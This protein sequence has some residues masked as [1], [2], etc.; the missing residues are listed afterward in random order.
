MVSVTSTTTLIVMVLLVPFASRQLLKTRTAMG[1]DLIIARAGI[2]SLAFGSLLV[3]LARTSEQFIAA[4]VFYMTESCYMPA[5]I[6]I[7]AAMAGVDNLQSERTGSL[8]MAVVF[9]NN[10]GAI[11]AGPIVS[12]LLRAGMSRGG[13]WVGLPF[14]AEAAI[15]IFTICIVFSIRESRYRHLQAQQE[16]EGAAPAESDQQ[17]VRS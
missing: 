13:D 17:T 10:I 15:Q 1:K 7:I 11:V 12:S 16:E 2:L 4:L 8:Y 9:M 6:S 14:F 3:G 5:I